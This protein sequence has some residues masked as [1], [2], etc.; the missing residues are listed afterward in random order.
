MQHLTSTL[1]TGKKM[2]NSQQNYKDT[3]PMHKDGRG[4]FNGSTQTCDAGM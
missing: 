3:N 2:R 4:K 1:F